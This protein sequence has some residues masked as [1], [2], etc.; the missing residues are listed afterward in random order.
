MVTAPHGPDLEAW[1]DSFELRC[2]YKAGRATLNG[3]VVDDSSGAMLVYLGGLSA[4]SDPQYWALLW[5]GEVMWI[6]GF[7][8]IKYDNKASRIYDINDSQVV[9]FDLGEVVPGDSP[10]LGRPGVYRLLRQAFTRYRA[11][12]RPDSLMGLRFEGE[13]GRK[14]AT[15]PR[16]P[17]P[18]RLEPVLGSGAPCQELAR[19]AFDD[20]ADQWEPSPLPPDASVDPGGFVFERREYTDVEMAR[21]KAAGFTP[22]TGRTW[23]FWGPVVASEADAM[24]V[25]M[26]GGPRR[27]PP[28]HWG[29]LLGEH[30]VTFEGQWSSGGPDILPGVIAIYRLDRAYPYDSPLLA[31]PRALR[32]ARQAFTAYDLDRHRERLYSIRFEGKIGKLLE[33]AWQAQ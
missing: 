9:T 17:K 27:E 4:P 15:A 6:R 18:G 8:R 10:L 14:L 7:R 33:E 23:H 32:L 26:G 22:P 31:H 25:Y 29:F 20:L 16:F 11:W 28:L 1:F 24:L 13:L 5:G 19:T 30:G 12:A 2:P 3:V 21:I